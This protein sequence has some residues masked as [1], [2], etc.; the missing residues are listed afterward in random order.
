MVGC[1]ERHKGS[2]AVPAGST[3]PPKA[4]A[5]ASALGRTPK[6]AGEVVVSGDGAPRAHGPYTLNG[7]YRVRFEQIDPEDPA[8]RFTG[9]TTFVAVAA[10]AP[11]QETGPGVVPLVRGATRTGTATVRLNGRLWINVSFGDFP[12]VVRLTPLPG[13]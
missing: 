13:G 2:P 1:G 9:Q 10:P 4:G 8:Q 7:R 6:A 11:D 3:A 12:Y 5:R